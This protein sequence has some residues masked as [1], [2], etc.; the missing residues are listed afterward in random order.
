MKINLIKLLCLGLVL[1]ML[2]AL[3]GCKSADDKTESSAPTNSVEST[4]TSSDDVSS[5]EEPDEE[6]DEEYNEYD[7]VA[8]G[9][10]TEITTANAQMIIYNYLD[11]Q[12]RHEG[13]GP[14]ALLGY[15]GI[16]KDF[17][18]SMDDIITIKPTTYKKTN[19]K[20]ADYKNKL[21][22]YMS[23]KRM[24]EY[25]LGDGL[26][27][28][29]DGYLY[30]CD[31]GASGYSFS[32][33]STTFLKEENGVHT[34]LVTCELDEMGGVANRY[35]K[36]NII[37]E[38][39]IYVF[40]SYEYIQRKDILF[41]GYDKLDENYAKEI[42]YNFYNLRSH[43]NGDTEKFVNFFKLV[44]E[45]KLDQKTTV[46]VKIEEHNIE[47]WKTNIKY[48]DLKNQLLKYVSKDIAE[49]TFLTNDVFAEKDG[50][51]YIAPAG[52]VGEYIDVLD[53][54]L[55]KEDSGKYEYQVTCKDDTFDDDDIEEFKVKATIVEQNG[56]YVLDAIE[57]IKEQ[58][59]FE[60]KKWLSAHQQ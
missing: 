49:E 21:L 23:Q 50:Y 47:F 11:L 19:V 41:K 55:L 38:N 40:D 26:C 16:V 44:D 35:I 48:K 25:F 58:S 10:Y 51:V 12:S 9:G 46:T 54:K 14:A 43:Y 36:A 34:Y 39:G 2:A 53:A 59:L 17:K 28:E 33:F 45:V 4:V 6:T 3:V 42:V 5:E 18:V 29:K 8:K 1:V 56:V 13:G 24:E 30:I 60:F 37:K 27:T 20:Y 7:Y 32:A 57:E 15:L 22:T 52:G 31:A